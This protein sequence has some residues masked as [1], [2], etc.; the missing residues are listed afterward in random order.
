MLH[1]V[2]KYHVI[3]LLN[4]KFKYIIESNIYNW[5]NYFKIYKN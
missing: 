2:I 3:K 4:L 5:K 1:D